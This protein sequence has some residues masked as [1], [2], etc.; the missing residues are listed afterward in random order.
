MHKSWDQAYSISLK[1]SLVTIDPLFHGIAGGNLFPRGSCCV[2]HQKKKEKKSELE[3][4]LTSRQK[5]SRVISDC[6]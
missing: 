1:R 6:Y 3:Q 5:P 4:I 2:K